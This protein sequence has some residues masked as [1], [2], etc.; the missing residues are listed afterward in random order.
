M[1]SSLVARS[2]EQLDRTLGAL[3]VHGD[4]VHHGADVVDTLSCY[5]RNCRDAPARHRVVL[6]G[7]AP[8]ALVRDSA[9]GLRAFG[10][11]CR[12]QFGQRRHFTL[13]LERAPEKPARPC[14]L[15]V[16]FLK[17][18]CGFD[19]N[20][21]GAEYLVLRQGDHVEPLPPPCDP[22]GW[23]Y[24]HHAESAREGWYPPSLPLSA[25]VG[26]ASPRP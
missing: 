26:A 19:G 11:W 13:V 22:E 12:S 21:Y 20:A 17:A 15:A 18:H 9:A 4:A 1:A 7:F 23:G 8:E 2:R 24:G 14:P 5:Q 6:P 3:H 16:S 10:H 25:A